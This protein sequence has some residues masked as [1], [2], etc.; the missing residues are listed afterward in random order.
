M[1]SSRQRHWLPR[2]A[3]HWSPRARNRAGF[4]SPSEL[5]AALWP[6]VVVHVTWWT[7]CLTYATKKKNNLIQF[8]WEWCYDIPRFFVSKR[9]RSV[10]LQSAAL[11]HWSPAAEGHKDWPNCCAMLCPHLDPISTSSNS[12]HPGILLTQNL[13]GMIPISLTPAAETMTLEGFTS[14]WI[15]RCEWR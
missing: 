14:L 12:N 11:P 15:I 2:A 10:L 4:P 1:W 13:S 6:E 3:L 5:L 8:G 9:S 7:F